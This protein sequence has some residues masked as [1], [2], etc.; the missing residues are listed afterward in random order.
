[1]PLWGL[2]TVAALCIYTS[3][4]NP[5]K[6]FF[7]FYLTLFSASQMSGRKGAGGS[8]SGVGARTRSHDD[9]KALVWELQRQVEG[10]RQEISFKD[11]LITRLR[12][13]LG[14]SIGEELTQY[15]QS[16]RHKALVREWGRAYARAAVMLCKSQVSGAEASKLDPSWVSDEV[17]REV[18]AIVERDV[19]KGL[20][21]LGWDC[22]LP[23]SLNSSSSDEEE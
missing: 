5:L 14:G 3:S 20:G 21:E 17:D 8:S 18:G 16:R 4:S 6:L 19:M 7:Y 12:G 2:C 22:A 11:K 10:Q 9:T 23:V 15:Q 13:E 1:M